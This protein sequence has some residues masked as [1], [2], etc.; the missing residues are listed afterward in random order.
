MREAVSH[1]VVVRTYSPVRRA[2]AAAAALLGAFA[3]YVVFE[4]GR[5]NAG[6]DRL[7]VAQQRA[8]LQAAIEHLKQDN[9]ELN[10]RLAELDTQRIGWAREQAEVSRTIGDLQAQVARQSQDLAFYRGV[11]AQPATA[12]LG[13]SIQKLHIGATP[14]HARFRVHLTLVRTV[15]GD[16]VVNGSAVLQVE[17]ETQGREQSLGLAALTAGAQHELRYSFRYYQ[18]LDQ[19]ITIPNDLRPERLNVEVR[20]S[21]KGIAPLS[22]TFLWNVDAS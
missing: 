21:R 22:Q 6:Y 7:A 9:H 19:D 5:Y 16:D 17:G 14:E 3:L 12:P 18:N 10:L 11:G 4:L 13:V 8:E 2:L 20:S 1:P 15:R